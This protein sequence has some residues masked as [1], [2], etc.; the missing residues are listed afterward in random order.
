MDL[1]GKD[2]VGFFLPSFFL[3]LR[4]QGGVLLASLPVEKTK[5]KGRGQAPPPPFKNEGCASSSSALSG[6]DMFQDLSGCLRLWQVLN[7]IHT[8]FVS[9]H[10]RL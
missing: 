10:A 3:L 9:I 2:Q 4:I 1:R 6:G 5:W 7:R 8:M